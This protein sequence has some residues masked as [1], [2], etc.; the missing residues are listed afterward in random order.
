MSLNAFSR[1]CS[2]AGIIILTLV[3]LFVISSGTISADDG[4]QEGDENS[5]CLICHNNPDLTMEL[6]SGEELSVYV[7]P[8]IFN[9]SVHGMQEQKCTACH[10][11]I[12]GY[13]HPPLFAVD[14]RDLSLGLYTACRQCHGEQY[15]DTV[16]SVHMRTMAGGDRNA[17][18]CTDCHGYHDV[19]PPDEPRLRIAQTCSKCHSTIYNEYTESVHGAALLEE[20]NPD[21]PT[22]IDCHGVH[23]IGDPLTTQFRL[24]SP[25]I[26]ADCHSD[27]VRMNRYDLT[28]DVLDSY[29]ADFHGTTVELFAKQSPDHPSN[30]AVCFDCHGVH[31]IKAVTDPEATVVKENLLTTCRQCHPDATTNFPASWVGHYRVNRENHPL[32]YYVDLFYK[33]LIPAVVGFFVLFVLLDVMRS[34]LERLGRSKG[35]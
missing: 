8:D 26:C 17:P 18:V 22:C 25:Q 7:A 28:T 3:T 19:T 27:P 5:V 21:V 15:Q 11:N 31:N 20:S 2:W 16:D 1:W 29:V 30:K 12:D 4:R 32:V 9:A 13:P 35:A 14:R 34:V 6:P 10:N 33:I 24:N 23:D